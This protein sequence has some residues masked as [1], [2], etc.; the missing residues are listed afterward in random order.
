[1]LLLGTMTVTSYQPIAAQ[2]DDSPTYTSIGDRTTKFGVAVSQDL[3]KSGELHYGDILYVP[4]Y[5]YRVVNDT[6][7]IRHKR[8]IDLLVFTR[9]EEKAVGT[10]T[11]KIYRITQPMEAPNGIKTVSQKHH[12]AKPQSAQKRTGQS[13]PVQ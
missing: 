1:M 11:L 4:G 3:L 8:H 6:M 9:N 12:Y 2:T 7:N 13:F 10:R 5:G